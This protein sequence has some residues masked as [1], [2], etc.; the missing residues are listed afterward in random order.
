MRFYF[1]LTFLGIVGYI[2]AKPAPQGPCQATPQYPCQATQQSPCQA[3]QQYPCQ[4]TQQYPCQATQQYP[5]A[6]YPSS[7]PQYEAPPVQ[8]E[9]P[10]MSPS[11]SACCSQVSQPSGPSSVIIPAAAPVNQAP[12]TGLTGFEMPLSTQPVPV[13]GGGM[14]CCQ[15]A[16]PPPCCLQLKPGNNQSVTV[17]SGGQV[18]KLTAK[19]EKVGQ[20]GQAAPGG[21]GTSGNTTTSG[22]N[23]TTLTTPAPTSTTVPSSQ[24]C[25][26]KGLAVHNAKRQIHNAPAMKLNDQLN[27]DAQAYA[28]KLA[29]GKPKF[30]AGLV[31][32]GTSDG[33]NL[34]YSCVKPDSGHDCSV[35]VEA[36]YNEV[37]KYDFNSPGFSDP[38]GHFTQVVWKAS[39]EL[40]MGKSKFTRDDGY[41]CYI[42]VGHY[43]AKGNMANQFETNVLKGSYSG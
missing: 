40:G 14:S 25:A 20:A 34:G 8:M 30:P 4:A 24:E 42:V 3:T 22:G 12:A 17:T 19:L 29:S 41:T 10:I 21:N 35:T 9:Q 38:T 36:W 11:L 1:V 37:K 33:E 23:A 6:S 2:A 18:Y 16:N 43:K 27:K 32:S 28:D 15:S 13:I 7:I 26:S 39:T 5:C 31:H